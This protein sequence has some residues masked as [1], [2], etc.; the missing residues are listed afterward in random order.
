MRKLVLFLLVLLIPL[1]YEGVPAHA[2]C[3]GEVGTLQYARV[4]SDN[5]MLYRTNGG[6]EENDN[7]YF[8]LPEGY[9]VRLD[10]AAA[11]DY[12]KVAYDGLN[13]YVKAEDVDIVSYIPKLKYASGQT[14]KI[15]LKDSDYCNFREFPAVSSQKLLETGIPNGTED[16][17]FYNYVTAE[18]VNWYFIEYSGQK[19]Y[20]HGDYAVVTKAIAVNDGAAEPV[21]EITDPSG[22]SGN[23]SKQPQPLDLTTLIILIAVIG[24]PAIVI[25]FM[26]FRPRRRRP[27]YRPARPNTNRIPRYLDEGYDDNVK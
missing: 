6:A 15:E 24:I 19:G 14:L 2:P 27:A 20:V 17:K 9:Y 5:V 25:M 13:G 10:D 22:N 8:L 18:T 1:L 3:S 4:L 23:K 7:R 21:L 16:I 11:D 26:L 12:Y